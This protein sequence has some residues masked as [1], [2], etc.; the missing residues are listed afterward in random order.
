MRYVTRSLPLA[1]PFVVALSSSASAQDEPAAAPAD[2]PADAAAAEQ[3]SAEPAL[4][5]TTAAAPAAPEA[6]PEPAPAEEPEPE[7]AAAAPAAAAEPAPADPAEAEEDGIP[8]WF[9]IDSDGL[10]L[11]LWVGATHSLG[12]VDI[13]SD[14]YVD[15]GTFAEFDI[16]PAFSFGPLALTPMVGIGFDWSEQ[17]ATSLIAPQLFTILDLD[18]IYFESWIQGFLYS[19]FTE[20]AD[21]DLY[22]RNFLLAKLSDDFHIGPQMEATLAL[23]NDRDTLSSLP[24]GGRI[25]LAYGENNLLGLF[26][27]Y[28]TQEDARQV[29]DGSETVD[30]VTGETVEGT[31]ERALV[32]RFTFVR[33]W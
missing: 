19:P 23:N 11:Q 16:G 2:A 20:G 7:P 3:A 9:R 28:E 32:G 8:G 31:T 6:D 27:G 5:Q 24:V 30:P 21:N 15:S 17:R 33:T 25:N 29:T 10:G 14:I 4:P 13:A 1:V 26:L 18:M 12:P 22:T